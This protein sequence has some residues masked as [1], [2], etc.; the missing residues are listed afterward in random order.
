V[1][2]K[3]VRLGLYGYGNR[4]RA[5]LDSLYGEDEYQ[6]VAAYDICNEADVFLI[7]LDPFAHYDAFNERRGRYVKFF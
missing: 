6:V 1:K 7:S 3:T 5:L 2:K 4:T